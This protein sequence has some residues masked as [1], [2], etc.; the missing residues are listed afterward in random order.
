MFYKTQ[1]IKQIKKIKSNEKLKKSNKKVEKKNKK[2][3]KS[4][5][6]DFSK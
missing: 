3:D 4:K 1:K 6:N 5:T 2:L